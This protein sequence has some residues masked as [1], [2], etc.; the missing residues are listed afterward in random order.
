MP[1]I[2]TTGKG[3]RAHWSRPP[4]PEDVRALEAVIEEAKRE[5]RRHKP[6]MKKRSEVIAAKKAKAAA[7][8]SSA[9]SSEVHCTACKT[10]SP[11]DKATKRADGKL[12]CPECGA[13]IDATASAPAAESIP[14]PPDA[15]RPT[16]TQPLPQMYCSTCG[17]PWPRDAEGRIAPAGCPHREGMVDDPSKAEHWEPPAGT[18]APDDVAI[19]A[20]LEKPFN[21]KVAPA[22]EGELPP[23]LFPPVRVDGNRLEADWGKMVFKVDAY[24]VNITV[25]PFTGTATVPE[26]ADR[27]IEGAKLL[28]DLKAMA[29]TA[30]AEQVAWYIQKLGILEKK[31]K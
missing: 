2:T 1:R 13:A 31:L 26:G 17:T 7:E 3:Y 5:M 9:T 10:V 23:T 30:F 11:R 4:S 29:D 22:P 19:D 15:K 12:E 18:K 28:R 27:V 25:G 24:G 6:S 20:A 21:P 14:P 8:A 16:A